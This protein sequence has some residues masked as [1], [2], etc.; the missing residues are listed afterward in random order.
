MNNENSWILFRGNEQSG[1]FSDKLAQELSLFWVMELGPMVSSAICH[2]NIVY[3]ST[4]TGKI[5]AIDVYKKKINWQKRYWIS[6]GILIIT[7]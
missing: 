4:I 1:I 7:L 3:N 5:F 6:F 2:D